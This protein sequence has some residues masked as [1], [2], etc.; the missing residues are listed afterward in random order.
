M[1]RLD[2]DRMLVAVLEMGSFAAAAARLGTSSGQASKMISR[3]EACLGVQLIKR[4]TRALSPTEV[5]QTYYQ[6]IKVLLD[7]LDALDASVRSAADAPSGR[8]RLTSSISFGARQLAPVLV[9]FARQY[10]AI[11]LDVD[12]SDQMVNLVDE[13]YDIALRI[14]RLDDSSLVARKLCDVRIVLA[15]SPDYLLRRGEPT[16]PSD[17]RFHDCIVDTNFR[18][19]NWQFGSNG[20]D[21]AVSISIN[22]RLHFANADACLYAAM[23]GLGITRIPSFICGEH[24]RSGRLTPLLPQ[25]EMT[26]LGP[27]AIY[28]PARHL[29]TKVRALVDYLANRFHGQPAWDQGW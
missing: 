28:P 12:F 25:R 16:Q 29:A 8:L 19:P 11:I 17:L 7:E 5:G 21:G 15:A 20:D 23:S 22:S 26:P 9:D 24:F 4:T 10:P 6:R 18:D 27:Y 3:L 13:G 1:E 2:C 14:G